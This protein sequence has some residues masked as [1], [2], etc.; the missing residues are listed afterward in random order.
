MCVGLFCCQL[1]QDLPQ[2]HRSHELPRLGPM[3]RAALHCAGPRASA[4]IMAHLEEPGPVA[5][6]VGV[7]F[8]FAGSLY[9]THSRVCFLIAFLFTRT[10]IVG[11][12]EQ[13]Q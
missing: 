9:H 8:A 2:A 11:S 1:V 5:H 13:A 3:A 4:G 6:F 12:S 10:G 7:S